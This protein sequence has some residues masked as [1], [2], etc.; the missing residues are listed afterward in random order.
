MADV[1]VFALVTWVVACWGFV[2][3]VCVCVDA[4]GVPG[5]SQRG[6]D[7]ITGSVFVMM[8]VC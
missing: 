8:L 7:R 4:C 6:A 1:D 5:G 2:T 3:G